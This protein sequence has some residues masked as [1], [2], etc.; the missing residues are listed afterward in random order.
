MRERSIGP[1]PAPISLIIRPGQRQDT[2]PPSQYAAGSEPGGPSQ[3]YPACMQFVGKSWLNAVMVLLPLPLPPAA[4]VVV[5]VL[6]GVGGWETGA[7]AVVI[8]LIGGAKFEGEGTML[9][10]VLVVEVGVTLI[11]EVTG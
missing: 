8:G 11:G 6:T 3:T 1:H 5:V 10:E 4:G 9:A 2:H 7:G